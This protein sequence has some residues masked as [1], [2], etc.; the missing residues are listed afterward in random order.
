MLDAVHRASTFVPHQP[1]ADQHTHLS[2]WHEPVPSLMPQLVSHIS[3][4]HLSQNSSCILQVL[5]KNC[6]HLTSD[7]C[8]VSPLGYSASHQ[9]DP[10]GKMHLEA[11][12]P[13]LPRHIFLDAL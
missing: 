11:S 1:V 4:S 12:H 5:Q 13:Q 8:S 2:L 9:V 7:C 10:V 3:T 6:L